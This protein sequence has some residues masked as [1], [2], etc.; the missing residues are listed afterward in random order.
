MARK[1]SERSHSR[2]TQ[3]GDLNLAPIM[4]ILVILIPMLIFVF[5]FYQIAVQQVAAPKMGMNKPT[6]TKEK[7]D[8]PKLNL[9]VMISGS[10]FKVKE[11]QAAGNPDVDIKRR[12][13]EICHL[14]D[15]SKNTV[16]SC[17][18]NNGDNRRTIKREYDYARL[19]S[20]VS[21]KK[22]L[23]GDSKDNETIN[24]APDFDVP[25][26]VVVRTI[27]AVSVKLT[28]GDTW[29]K[30]FKNFD[31]FRQAKPLMVSQKVPTDPSTEEMRPASLFPRITFVVA[32]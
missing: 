19:Y 10:G 14:A 9:T 28:T 15:S 21:Q 4:S 30:D 16:E 20:V 32:Q 31:V 17:G 2:K 5:Q 7:D 13:V 29:T 26:K 11:Q 8:K 27:D 23:H 1:P 24:I 12:D 18:S 25:W 22:A 3:G 6:E